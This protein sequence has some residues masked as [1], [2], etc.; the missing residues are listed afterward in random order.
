MNRD[1]LNNIQQVNINDIT[2]KFRSK[3][4]LYNFLSQECGA[5]LPRHNSTNI[6]FL[7]DIIMGEKEVDFYYF[8]ILQYISRK[9]IMIADV[10]HIDGLTVEDFLDYA[11]DKDSIKKYLP[12]E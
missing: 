11:N 7:K 3:K 6:Y 1:N 8:I 10:P 5:Y 12:N 9:D 4:E 2:S